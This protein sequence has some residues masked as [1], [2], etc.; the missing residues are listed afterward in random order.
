MEKALRTLATWIS[1]L[2]G[3]P[4]TRAAPRSFRRRL[5]LR[6]A[7]TTVL[8]ALGVLLMFVVLTAATLFLGS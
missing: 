4:A 6:R 5:T 8:I 7:A 3:S 1:V 2:V